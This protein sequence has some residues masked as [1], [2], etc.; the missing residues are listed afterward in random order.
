[1]IHEPT[2]EKNNCSKVTYSSLNKPTR[3]PNQKKLH[4]HKMTASAQGQPARREKS[5]KAT[6]TSFQTEPRDEAAAAG[7]GAGGLSSFKPVPRPEWDAALVRNADIPLS[8]QLTD[9]EIALLCRHLPKL[10]LHVH[11]SGAVLES[12]LQELCVASGQDPSSSRF[13][14]ESISRHDSYENTW[15]ETVEAFETIRRLTASDTQVLRRIAT[16]AVHFH[17]DDGCVYFEMR[18][19][20]KELPDR[21]TF[22][23]ELVSALKLAQAKYGLITRLLLSV[24]RGA[25]VEDC[26]ETIDIAIET[27]ENQSKTI[28]GGMLVGVEMGGNPNCG[29]WA[30]D[31]EPHFRRAR[32]AGLKVSLHFAEN[33]GWNQEHQAI[34]DFR[35]DRVGHAVYMSEAVGERLLAQKIP[36]E[37]CMTCHQ[38]FYKVRPA[39]NILGTLL[40][41]KHPAILCTDNPCLL[42]TLSSNEYA[43][44]I[45]TFGLT[46]RQVHGMVLESVNSI[47]ADDATRAKVRGV[48]E[49]KLRQLFPTIKTADGARRAQSVSVSGMDLLLGDRSLVPIVV[50]G[51]AVAAGVAFVLASR[52]RW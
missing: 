50:A 7:A 31:L 33:K 32:R 11:L 25:S 3:N 52:S 12:T 20:L 4:N 16:E 28:G 34:L 51:A 46:A 22:L 40:K 8:D 10:E 15:R 13:K 36:V 41:H 45:K 9:A 19:G 2:E 35:P 47:F 23:S 17:A 26:K 39:D 30:R 14:L 1:M 42:Q 21:R 24:N 43:L 5:W 44:A 18:T 37:V 27:F 38:A 29:D 6:R 48:C 49:A